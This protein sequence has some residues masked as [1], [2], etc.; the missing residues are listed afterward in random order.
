M[1]ILV[2][3]ELLIQ[4]GC[5]YHASQKGTIFPW[6]YVIMIPGIGPAAYFM[7]EILPDMAK[8]RGGQKVAMDLRTVLDPDREFRERKAEAELTQTPATKAAFAE[9]CARRGMHDE[10]VAMY[11]AALAGVY[12]DDPH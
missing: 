6:I 3:A 5:I 11:R 10:A 7:F 9:E 8:S 4:A 1:P 12:A 2:L